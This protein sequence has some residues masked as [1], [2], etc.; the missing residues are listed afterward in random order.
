MQHIYLS[1]AR[2]ILTASLHL[3]TRRRYDPKHAARV[4]RYY[5]HLLIAFVRGAHGSASRHRVRTSTR[6]SALEHSSLGTRTEKQHSRR[7]SC[8]TSAPS[9]SLFLATAGRRSHRIGC[10]LLWCGC[11]VDDVSRW[12]C[13]TAANA[14]AHTTS[15]CA[16]KMCRCGL[17]L[18]RAGIS[19]RI[20]N[21]I[22]GMRCAC[23]IVPFQPL[24][25][26][27]KRS[28]HTRSRARRYVDY[29]IGQHVK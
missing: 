7:S 13:D 2:I 29:R 21:V 3:G 22:H 23:A 11:D 19:K 28:K 1:Y 24:L 17:C 14:M 27:R 10:W 16:D 20:M 6:A 4:L 8:T 15:M 5:M 25:M 18:A 9:V 12:W 26:R